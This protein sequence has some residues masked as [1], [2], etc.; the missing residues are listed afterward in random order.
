MNKIPTDE[1]TE[2]ISLPTD[3]ALMVMTGRPE[4]SVMISKDRTLNVEETRA[5]IH[6][7]AVLMKTNNQLRR[8]REE[9]TLKIENALGNLRGSVRMFEKM[10][11]LLAEEE[12]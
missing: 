2:D 1:L 3:F 8:Q 6:A 9:Q 5:V 4:L 11:D 10:I 7:L 12:S